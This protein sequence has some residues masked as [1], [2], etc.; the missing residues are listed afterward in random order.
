M[1]L[2]SEANHFGVGKPD[3]ILWTFCK[4]RKKYRRKRYNGRQGYHN[5]HSQE[6]QSERDVS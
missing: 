6:A 5:E 3:R 1:K 4:R 2:L